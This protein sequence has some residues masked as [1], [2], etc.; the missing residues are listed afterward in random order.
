MTEANTT[1]I[2]SIKAAFNNKV[3]VR[4]TS[5]GFRK[6]AILD[7]AGKETGEYN[8]R[9]NVVLNIPYP[10][11]EGIIAILEAGGKQL[12]LLQEAVYDIVAGR[13]RQVINDDENITSDNFDLT[14]LAWE[15]IANLPK[16]ERRGG[17]ISKETWDE[18]LKDY[19]AVMP[20]VTGKTLDQVKNAAKLFA[21]KFNPIKTNKK[22]ITV[23]K[24]Q[25]DIWLNNSARAEEFTECYEFLTNKAD[26]LLS[27]DE[28]KLLENL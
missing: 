4:E 18:F 2:E 13:A 24:G 14:S 11:V 17:G 20:S 21:A 9:P 1:A 22:V 15:I 10:S 12:E 26:N 19:I 25:L 8:K 23:L 28:A 3:D 27:Q 5:F 7:D 16:A 6:V